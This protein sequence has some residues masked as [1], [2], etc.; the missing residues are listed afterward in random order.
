MLVSIRNAAGIGA[1]MIGLTGCYEDLFEF[2][3]LSDEGTPGGEVVP[4]V[5][6]TIDGVVVKGFAYCDVIARDPQGTALSDTS[7]KPAGIVVGQDNAFNEVIPQP[8]AADV[9]F[10]LTIEDYVGPVI[11][12][13]TDCTYEDETTSFAAEIPM[14]RAVINIPE[15]GGNLDLSVTPLTEAA[16]HIAVARADG[17]VQGMTSGGV[18]AAYR[19]VTN[20]FAAGDAF[21]PMTTVPAVASLDTSAGA[22]EGEIFY[23]LVLAAFSGAADRRD[24]LFTGLADDLTSEGLRNY[25]E[26]LQGGAA[27]FDASQRNRTGRAAS[28]V[29]GEVVEAALGPVPSAP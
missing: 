16:Y 6:A 10:T 3:G 11:V 9:A 18:D 1:M 7:F 8:T 26:I 12:E 5:S 29:I 17:V 13:A 20:A 21:D 24:E 25:Y 23:G 28:E 14:L 4:G 2:D 22:T 27:T 15:A 19:L